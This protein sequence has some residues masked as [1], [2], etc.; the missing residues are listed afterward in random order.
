[1]Y[2]QRLIDG[3]RLYDL[4][5]D[6]DYTAYGRIYSYEAHEVAREVLKDVLRLIEVAPTIKIDSTKEDN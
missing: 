2:K 4:V 1:M 6:I 3:N 5:E